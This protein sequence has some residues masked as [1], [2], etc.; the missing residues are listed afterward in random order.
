MCILENITRDNHGEDMV[1][2][3][4]ATTIPSTTLTREDTIDQRRT[5]LTRLRRNEKVSEPEPRDA[6]VQTMDGSLE[7]LP[8]LRH[9]TL[10][11]LTEEHDLDDGWSEVRSRRRKKTT[12]KGTSQEMLEW[13][14]VHDV[15]D[16]RITITIDS[17]AAVSAVPKNIAA[18]CAGE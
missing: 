4:D 12:T 11:A 14:A 7:R 3:R 5:I 13:N 2:A 18:E 15:N 8:S 9:S 17:G 6:C 10:A 1:I 16:E